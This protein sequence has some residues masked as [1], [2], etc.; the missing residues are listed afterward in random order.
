MLNIDS[1]GSGMMQ[2][3]MHFYFMPLM[4]II[5]FLILCSIELGD[6]MPFMIIA[7]LIELGDLCLETWS[8][9]IVNKRKSCVVYAS[10]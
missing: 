5:G 8:L 3:P 10:F 6:F 9:A 7:F 2:D 4:I 1:I